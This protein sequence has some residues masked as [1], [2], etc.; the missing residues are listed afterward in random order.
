MS[1]WVGCHQKDLSTRRA[2]SQ[3][4]KWDDRRQKHE[5]RR[6]GGD[7]GSGGVQGSQPRHGSGVGK[8]LFSC[9]EA[10][11]VA[12]SSANRQTGV[13]PAGYITLHCSAVSAVLYSAKHRMA[14]PTGY[15][16]GAH[17]LA[18]RLPDRWSSAGAH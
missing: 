16:T 1:T 8:V 5:K 9:H 12:Q 11:A 13:S 3:T 7:T 2:W 17:V 10:K 15:A 18:G 6:S 4:A 14:Q